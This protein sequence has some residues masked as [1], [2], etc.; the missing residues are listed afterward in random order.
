MLLVVPDYS[1]TRAEAFGRP[2]A[3]P[4][5]TPWCLWFAWMNAD[6]CCHAEHTVTVSHCINQVSDRR[7]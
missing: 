1:A 6:L 7:L 4:M 3:Q 5:N 2:N